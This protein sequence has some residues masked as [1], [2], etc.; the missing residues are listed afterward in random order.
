M[1]AAILIWMSLWFSLHS[2]FSDSVNTFG[3]D[4]LFPPAH[5]YIVNV[6]GQSL[7]LLRSLNLPA[8]SITSVPLSIW[9]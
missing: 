4:L 9:P 6:A 1:G 5:I 8:G 7:V 2:N 3:N